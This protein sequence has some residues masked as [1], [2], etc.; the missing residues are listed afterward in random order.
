[1]KSHLSVVD[2]KLKPLTTVLSK[3]LT[4]LQAKDPGEIFLEPVDTNEVCFCLIFDLRVEVGLEV[5]LLP[6]PSATR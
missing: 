4:Q 5:T 2:L 1:M 6:V 3:T